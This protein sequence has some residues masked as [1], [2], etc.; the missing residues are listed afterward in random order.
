VAAT[1]AP[2]LLGRSRKGWTLTGRVDLGCPDLSHLCAQAVPPAIR[3]RTSA[4]RRTG[5]PPS[6]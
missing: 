5:N 1:T 2:A 3:S 6:Y 4:A